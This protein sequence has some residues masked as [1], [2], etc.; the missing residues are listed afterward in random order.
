MYSSTFGTRAFSVVGPT[1]WNSL[2]NSLC[3]PA[4]ESD[5]YRLNLKMYLFAGH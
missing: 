2:P 4:V 1:V 3:D 5:R